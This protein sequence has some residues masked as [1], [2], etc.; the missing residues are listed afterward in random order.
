MS[1]L[2]TNLGFP[3]IGRNRELKKLVE[4]HWAG[5]IGEQELLS[6]V[7]NIRTSHWKLQQ[8]AG[9][10]HIPSGDFSLYDH[11]LDTAVMFGAIPSR[12]QA[13]QPG[14]ETYFAM[15]RGLQRSATETKPALDV[16]AM[17]MKKWFNTNYHY[18]VPEFNADQ[19]FHLSGTKPLDEFLEAKAIGI[20]TRPVVLGPVSFLLLGKPSKGQ[21]FNLLSL[22]DNVLPIYAQVCALSF[23]SVCVFVGHSNLSN[24][25]S[26]LSI[27]HC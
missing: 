27:M 8:E 17:E 1:I 16:S 13:L 22:L 21:A 6:E 2:A 10:D 3:R 7:K 20:A 23:V 18:V 15:A 26:V 11:V 9:L 25:A 19:K 24:E 12:Y 4:A 14:L 5:K